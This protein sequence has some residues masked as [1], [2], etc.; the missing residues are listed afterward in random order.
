MADQT[1]VALRAAQWHIGA[2]AAAGNVL[3][4]DEYL[5]AIAHGT[6]LHAAHTIVHEGISR[7]GRMRVHFYEIDMEGR[8]DPLCRGD[9]N[10]QQ[11]PLLWC[12]P[13]SVRG[14]ALYSID[15]QTERY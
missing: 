9:V 8:P 11:K 14:E 5:F 12:M 6:T 13:R 15:H 7:S 2:S 10:C 3:P 4:V 1:A